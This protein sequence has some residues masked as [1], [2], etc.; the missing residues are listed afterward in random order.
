MEYVRQKNRQ[1]DSLVWGSLTLAPINAL[2]TLHTTRVAFF[3]RA[4]R[5]SRLRQRAASCRGQESLDQRYVLV[6]Y[7][8]NI[9][10]YM[11]QSI[12]KYNFFCTGKVDYLTC[13]SEQ[14]HV[15]NKRVFNRELTTPWILAFSQGWDTSATSTNSSTCSNALFA[16][17]SNYLHT[18]LYCVYHVSLREASSA[19]AYI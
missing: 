16:I 13:G 14:P 9:F 1:F 6:I 18:C 4:T 7:N 17:A 11:P 5:L 2:S 15:V 19:H 10:F 8:S 3:D 12:T